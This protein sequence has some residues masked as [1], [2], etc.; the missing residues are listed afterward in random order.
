MQET[1]IIGKVTWLGVVSDSSI[2]LRA[3]AV[4]ELDLS[5]AGKAFRITSMACYLI[6]EICCRSEG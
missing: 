3:T 2:D 5:F 6:A 4:Q 1:E